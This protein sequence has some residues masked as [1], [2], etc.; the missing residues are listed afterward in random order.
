VENAESENI[1]KENEERKSIEK[2]PKENIEEQIRYLNSLHFSFRRSPTFFRH[3]PSS[4]FSPNS[5]YIYI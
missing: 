4:R 5:V 1:E 3:F 2:R